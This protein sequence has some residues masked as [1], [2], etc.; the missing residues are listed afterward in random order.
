MSAFFAFLGLAIIGTMVYNFTKSGS[1][2][3]S[4]VGTV[5]SFGNNLF[6]DLVGK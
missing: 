3:P 2:G 6:N 5:G 4:I 1:G